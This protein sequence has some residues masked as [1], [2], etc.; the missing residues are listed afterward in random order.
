ML[1]VKRQLR[2]LLALVWAERV[3]YGIGSVFVLI[4]IGAGLSYPYFVQQ[5]IDRGVMSGSIERVN[6]L[7]LIL[8]FLLLAEGGSTTLRDYFFNVAAER[9]TARLRQQVFDH[10]LRQEVAFFDRQRSGELTARLWSD[11]PAIGRVVGD[12]AADAFRFLLFGVCGTVLLFYTSPVLTMIVMLALPPIVVAAWLLGRRVKTLSTHAQNA[13]AESGGAAEESLAGIR[14]V[15]AFSQE[16]AEG[17]RYRRTID[18]AL[19]IARRKIQTTS[20]LSGVSFAMGEGAALLGLWAGGSLIVRGR[21]TSGQ[22]I[23]FVLYAFLVSR[24]F[25]NSTFFWADALKGLGATAWVFDLLDRAPALPRSGSRR[26]ETLDGAVTFDRVGFRYP[27]RPDVDALA[28]IE[29]RVAPNEVVALV[30]RSGAGKST[31]VN[32][33]LRFYEPASGHL[34]IDGHDVKDLDAAWLRQQIGVVMQEPVL[35]SGSIADNIR[36]GRPDATHEQVAAAAALAHAREFIDRFPAGLETTIGE[37]G[38][39][40]SGGQRQRLA[41]ARAV[42]RHPRILIL[43]EA[44][45]A[46][47]SENESFVQDALRALPYRPTTFVIAHRLSSVATV[48]RVVVLDRGRIVAVGRHHELLRSSDRYRQLVETQLVTA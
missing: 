19:E 32:L 25:R 43:D 28:D 16:G 41:I 38:L 44:T 15:R 5:L 42:L 17:A 21:M 47:D 10:L 35:F 11:V 34:L 24:G 29:L 6:R 13:Y 27:T 46:L 3:F 33:L 40:L 22:L 23:G 39:Q 36:Y 9:V 4:G 12:E 1:D 7:G 48:D 45:S 31:I 14:T 37:R 8:F 18:R 30:G 20:A 26:L 2:A